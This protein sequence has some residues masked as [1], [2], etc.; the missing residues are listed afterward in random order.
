MPRDPKVAA[1]TRILAA[2]T[3]SDR[4]ALS[5]RDC[6]NALRAAML[7]AVGVGVSRGAIARELRTSESRVRQYV[8]QAAAEAANK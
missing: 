5:D 3:A 1:M 7:A 6:R 8:M 2:K 4:A